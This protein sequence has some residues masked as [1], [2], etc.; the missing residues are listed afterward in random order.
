MN[1]IKSFH[2]DY[3][4]LSNFA[5]ALVHYGGRPYPSVEHGF[6]A[7]KSFDIK[8]QEKISKLKSTQVGYAKKLGRE[9]KIREDWD[10]ARIP[11]MKQLLIQKFT[12]NNYNELLLSTGDLELI[13]G[14][15]WHDNFWGDCMCKQCK[16]I[17]GQNNL[18]KILMELRTVLRG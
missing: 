8:F 6:V 14:N 16:E 13:E 4:G 2:G 9:I 18:G 3:K 12:I 1:V 7:A 5:A 10:E 11:I 17:K 15:F